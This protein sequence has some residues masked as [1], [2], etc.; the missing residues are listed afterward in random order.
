VTIERLD[1]A[2]GQMHYFDTRGVA[3]VYDLDLSDGVLTLARGR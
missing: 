2:R 1:A 3:R